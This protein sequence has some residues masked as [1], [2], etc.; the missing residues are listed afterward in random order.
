MAPVGTVVTMVGFGS[1]AQGGTGSVGV[2]FALTQRTSTSCSGFGLS[3]TNLLCF[4]Q[5]DNKG[6]CQ[7]DSGGPSFAMINNKVHVVGV[8]SFG[9]QD[10]AAFGADTRTDVEKTFLLTNNPALENKCTM[11]SEC[12]NGGICFMSQCLAQPFG[13]MGL[14]TTC[15]AGTEC[16]SGVCGAGPGG[17]KCSMSCSPE[18]AGTCPDGFECLGA[19]AGGACWPEGEDEG[20]GC[21][22]AGSQLPAGASTMLFWIGFVAL[23]LRRRRRV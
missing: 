2:Q 23:F 15:V 17:M 8:T 10:C 6:K 7:G 21:C 5:Q 18:T 1:T 13:P 9:D 11:D 3:N 22:D 12:T 14:G 4:N 19:G 20:G 16:E